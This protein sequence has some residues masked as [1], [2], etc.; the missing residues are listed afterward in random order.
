M[1]EPSFLHPGTLS[2]LPPL[3]SAFAGSLTEAEQQ[4]GISFEIRI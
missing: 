1:L 3:W 4:V 2:A